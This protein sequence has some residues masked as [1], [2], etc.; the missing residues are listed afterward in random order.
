VVFRMNGFRSG[1]LCVQACLTEH[2]GTVDGFA[3]RVRFLS[4]N[5]T[6]FAVFRF[7]VSNDTT[8]CPEWSQC[9]VCG[10]QMTLRVGPAVSSYLGVGSD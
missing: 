8:K 4:R 10:I 2:N 5:M 1:I 6:L 3:S 9:P 7:D